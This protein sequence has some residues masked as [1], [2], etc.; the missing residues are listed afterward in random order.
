MNAQPAELKTIE[1]EQTNGPKR[2]RKPKIQPVAAT[3][4]KIASVVAAT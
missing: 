2:R 4:I 1:C 3:V